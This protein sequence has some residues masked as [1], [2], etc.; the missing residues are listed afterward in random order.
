MRNHSF[1]TTLINSLFKANKTDMQIYTY[2]KQ[3]YDGVYQT[4]LENIKIMRK[5]FEK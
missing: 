3:N 2:L 4:T 5:K 1:K